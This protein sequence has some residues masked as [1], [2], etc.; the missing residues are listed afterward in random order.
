MLSQT[1][2]RRSLRESNGSLSRRV[3][4]GVVG[5]T[6]L[7]IAAWALFIA[8]RGD[9][10]IGPWD[11]GDRVLPDG[12]DPRDGL[13]V[14][15]RKSSCPEGAL[16]LAAAWPLG[17]TVPYAL[18][19]PDVRSYAQDPTGV[20]ADVEAIPF[21]STAALPP[22]ARDTGVHRN[23]WSIWTVPGTDARY[24]WLWD[25]DHAERWP[26]LRELPGCA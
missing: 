9:S 21:L 6:C 17:T 3:L 19:G 16:I 15:V 22:G 20:L 11:L 18:N 13:S 2:T 5:G 4:L 12:S 25:G 8:L 24:L 26:R 10:L 7:V 14:G 1:G 23:Q